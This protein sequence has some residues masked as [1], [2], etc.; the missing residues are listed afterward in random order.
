MN[1][2]PSPQE[3]AREALEFLKRNP[4]T[5]KEHIK[6]LIKEGIIDRTGRVICAKLFGEGAKQEETATDKENGE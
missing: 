2:T 4:M 1:P 3:L 5:S 6:F